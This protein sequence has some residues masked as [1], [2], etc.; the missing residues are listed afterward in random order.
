MR[1][2]LE[3]CAEKPANVE[4]S[5]PSPVRDRCAAPD[6]GGLSRRLTWA[7][8]LF[9]DGQYWLVVALAGVLCASIF[10]AN[11][12]IDEGVISLFTDY[13]QKTGDLRYLFQHHNARFSFSWPYFYLLALVR[14]NALD[15]DTYYLLRV[16]SLVLC[17][18]SLVAVHES[19]R[20]LV[21][22]RAIRSLALA[23]FVAFC[24][25]LG[26]TGARYDSPYLF[27]ASIALLTAARLH[28][29]RSWLWTC[30]GMLAAA[31]A[32]TTHPVGFG[33]IGFLGIVMAYYFV[34]R[35]PARREAAIVASVAAASAVL[36]IAGLLID[37][38][39]SEFLADLKGVQDQFHTFTANTV[40]E[41]RQRYSSLLASGGALPKAFI[42]CLALGLV[43]P[44]TREHRGAVRCCR[45][46]LAALVAF[47]ALIP[48]KWI[49]YLA[50]LLPCATVLGACHLSSVWRYRFF[51]WRRQWTC[52]DDWL[53]LRGIRLSQVLACAAAAYLALGVGEKMWV[54][55]HHN[56]LLARLVRPHGK[57]AS[58]SRRLA[59]FLAGKSINLYSDL[60]IIPLLG[61]ADYSRHCRWQPDY[62]VGEEIDLG[63]SGE[64]LV[65]SDGF[66]F[67]TYDFI[68]RHSQFSRYPPEKLTTACF[69]NDT[70]T[71]YRIPQ[72]ARG[73]EPQRHDQAQARV[74]PDARLQ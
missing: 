54:A 30:P 70:F 36:L 35:R 27:G 23:F 41:E 4:Q 5:E 26:L 34:V 48:T 3:I 64:Y 63:D 20:A 15:P 71:V 12:H 21:H 19:L 58:E 72:D 29:G 59:Q 13:F 24:L 10:A 66:R 60:T 32:G 18:L 39:P 50:L 28:Q 47:L 40:F 56:T 52:A 16:P 55:A 68:A 44:A 67:I 8:V 7:A 45:I 1:G 6:S 65:C 22:H 61:A 57:Q 51:P 38:T 17:M 25:H 73:Q 49:F 11:W 69:F 74:D 37:R 46:G 62:G 31:F 42:A 53:A 43:W 9:G 14:G 2:G 33:A